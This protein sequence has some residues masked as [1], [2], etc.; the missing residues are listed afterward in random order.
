MIF[1][2][3]PGDAGRNAGGTRSLKG[4]VFPGARR[5]GC[6]G[7]SNAAAERQRRRPRHSGAAPCRSRERRSRKTRHRD[8]SQPS[9]RRLGRSAPSFFREQ[10]H[11]IPRA[12]KSAPRERESVRDALSCHARPCAGHPRSWCGSKGVDGRDKPGHDS[13]WSK[14]SLSPRC[15]KIEPGACRLMER[16][17]SVAKRQL[18]KIASRRSAPHVAVSRSITLAI[19]SPHV[20]A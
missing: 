20:Q 8:G 19:A 13:G 17:V 10:R 12:R 16:K 14:A 18:S 15:L 11:R 2:S 1:R 9:Q 6:H 7:M 4:F 3:L 5:E